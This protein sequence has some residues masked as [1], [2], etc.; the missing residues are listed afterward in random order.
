VS[1]Q[2]LY[3]YVGPRA[4]ADRARAASRGA[5]VTSPADLLAWGR[6]GTLTFVIDETGALLVADRHAE[7]VACAGGGPVC[8]AGELAFEATGARV[9]LVRVSNQST[10]YCPEPECYAEVA[11]ALRAA[12]LEPPSAFDPQCDFRRC[13]SCAAINLIKANEF[14][15]AVCGADLPERYNG[16]DALEGERHA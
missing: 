12:G 6:A 4:I 15:C 14:E 13:P 2:R 8:A 11:R 16:Q 5:V 1:A 7:H 10:G 9:E 3:H